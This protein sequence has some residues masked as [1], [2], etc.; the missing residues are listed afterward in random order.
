MGLGTE[1]ALEISAQRKAPRQFVFVGPM[2]DNGGRHV[3]RELHMRKEAI[4]EPYMVTSVVHILGAVAVSRLL[5]ANFQS[6]KD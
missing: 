3:A 6:E 1:G 5:R 4:N 2:L